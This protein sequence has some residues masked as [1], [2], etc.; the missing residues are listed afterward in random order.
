MESTTFLLID[1]NGKFLIPC[2]YDDV[3]IFEST[4]RYIK[5][6]NDEV[7]ISTDNGNFEQN[8]ERDFD[9]KI[10]LGNEDCRT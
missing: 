4:E 8:N 6:K 5:V 10:K 9:C 3:D 2:Q 1:E 7:F